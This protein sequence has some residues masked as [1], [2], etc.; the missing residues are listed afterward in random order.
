VGSERQL[1]VLFFQDY[2]DGQGGRFSNSP[3]LLPLIGHARQCGFD[4]EFVSERQELLELLED[5]LVDVVAVSSMERMLPR[6]IPV[7]SAVRARRPDVVLML[8]GNSIETF[9]QDLCAAL[10]DVVAIGEGEHVFPALLR[11]MARAKGRALKALPPP[12]FRLE[13]AVRKVADGDAGGALSPVM[14]HS[15]LRATFQR[16]DPNGS[17]TETPQ[18]ETSG[19]RAERPARLSVENWTRRVCFPGTS[20]TNAPGK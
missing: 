17:I 2:D 6:S 18:P 7:A 15:V 20:S 11:A 3:G 19:T 12:H 4:V 14:F 9:A 10:F 16:R 5:P 13:A 1:R 8:G